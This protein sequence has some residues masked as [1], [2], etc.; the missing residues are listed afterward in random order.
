MAGTD[1]T[2]G[3]VGAAR[4]APAVVLVE[5]QLGQNIG[6]VARAMLN[7]GMTDLRLVNPRDGWPNENAVNAS[8]G[9]VVVL[10]RARV[11]ASVPDAL[12]DLQ[13]VYAT[14]ARARDMAKPVV[15]PRDAAADI[16]A[17]SDDGIRCGLL[18][19]PEAK[20]LH[21]DDIVLAD[22]ILNV[23][24]NPG[25]SSLNLAQAVL[26]IGYEWYQAACVAP[27]PPRPP[28]PV[29]KP[30]NRMPASKEALFGMFE[31]LEAELDEC[32]FLRNREKR[33]TMVRNLRNMFQRANLTDQ[34]VRTLRGVIVGL[35]EGRKMKRK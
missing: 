35:V 33:P 31:H 20:G 4:G 7:C 34:E 21:N 13:R 2:R 8:S 24:L 10:D 17:A 23:P 16:F 12:E 32:G 19:G 29:R 9:A 1:R 28:K 6:M 15:T 3:L 25:F 14:T 22:A 26:L 18:F 27:A 5:P 30:R 11:F